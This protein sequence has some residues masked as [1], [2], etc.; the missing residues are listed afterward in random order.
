MDAWEKIG[1]ILLVLALIFF[2]G[3][4]ILKIVSAIV[5]G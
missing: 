1:I 2:A 3:R 5:G 4:I